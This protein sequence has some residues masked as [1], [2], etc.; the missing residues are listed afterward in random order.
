MMGHVARQTEA[1]YYEHVRAMRTLQMERPSLRIT[2]AQMI[3]MKVRETETQKSLP[4]RARA[5][6]NDIVFLFHPSTLV[7]R[8]IYKPDMAKICEEEGH[9]AP[10]A[11]QS[12]VPRCT[13]CGVVLN[14]THTLKVL[15]DRPEPS[16]RH[17]WVD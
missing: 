12:P 15:K 4:V 14:A 7:P 8:K 6:W 10:K 2:H 13:V 1:Q 17:Y 16:V 5:I 3:A 11:G 9:V